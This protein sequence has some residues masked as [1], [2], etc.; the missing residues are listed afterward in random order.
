[1]LHYLYYTSPPSSTLPHTEKLPSLNWQCTSLQA[2]ESFVHLK[3]HT[4]SDVIECATIPYSYIGHNQL[5]KISCLHNT[6][7]VFSLVHIFLSLFIIYINC[8]T[9]FAIQKNTD[10]LHLKAF[11]AKFYATNLKKINA[12]LIDDTCTPP[13]SSLQTFWNVYYHHS[14]FLNLNITSSICIC[15]SRATVFFSQFS[16]NIFHGVFLGFEELP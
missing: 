7:G 10:S 11:E 12:F 5:T 16:L 1:M 13:F 2:T 3:L 8:S 9:V 15:N 14:N 6:R 4:S